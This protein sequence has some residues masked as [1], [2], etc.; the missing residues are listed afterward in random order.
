MARKVETP[1]VKKLLARKKQL[2]AYRV[3]LE[4]A[5]A[6]DAAGPHCLVIAL[7][8]QGITGCRIDGEQRWATIS[9]TF[10]QRLGLSRHQRTR[11]INCLEAAGLAEV[12]REPNHAPRVRLVAWKS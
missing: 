3:I 10:G 6:C 2:F 7:M 12:V 4:W 1:T 9:E 11:T 8:L 5:Q